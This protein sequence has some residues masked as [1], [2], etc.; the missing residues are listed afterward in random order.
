[1]ERSDVSGL[2]IKFSVIYNAMSI[3]SAVPWQVKIASKVVLS[4]FPV[5]YRF[6]QR[7]ELFQHGKMERPEY[8]FQTFKRHFDRS[9]FARK[10]AGF[11]GVE[12]GPGDTLFSALIAHAFGAAAYY[13]VD[14]GRFARQDTEPYLQMAAYLKEKGLATPDL[15]QVTRVDEIMSA[16]GA[17]YETDGLNSLRAIPDQ[18]V[19]FVW[20]QAVLEHVRRASFPETMREIR[21]ILRPDGVASHQIDLKDHLGGKLNNLRFSERRWESDFMSRSGFYTNRIRYKDML[22]IFSE[23]GFKTDVLNA[24]EW[25]SL[26]TPRNKMD[27]I[28]RGCS[29]EELCVQSFD[30]LLWPV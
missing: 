27:T 2:D 22:R 1:M 25:T 4:R 26:P 15:S 13:L 19:D 6:W 3:K 10:E 29:D 7:L 24:E 23:S 20:S 5:G 21:R 18:S 14:V 30:A 8:A 9:Q 16:C 28:F 11:V 17:R 12:L